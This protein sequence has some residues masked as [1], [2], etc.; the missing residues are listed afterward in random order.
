MKYGARLVLDVKLQV[1]FIRIGGRLRLRIFWVRTMNL[2][3]GDTDVTM[4][5]ELD[6][7]ANEVH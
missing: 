7:V 5:S 4:G 2:T 6:S 3:T 1:D